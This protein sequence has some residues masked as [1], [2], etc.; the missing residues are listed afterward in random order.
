MGA[1]EMS[2][3]DNEIFI[4]LPETGAA[5]SSNGVLV[6]YGLCVDIYEMGSE[7]HVLYVI[8]SVICLVEW[9]WLIIQGKCE[10]AG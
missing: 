2:V 8:L 9:T 5:L 6:V 7:C 10:G 4:F 1:D 3:Q